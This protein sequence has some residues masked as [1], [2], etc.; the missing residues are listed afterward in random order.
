MKKLYFLLSLCVLYSCSKEIPA[1]T[2]S[3]GVVT[4]RPHIWAKSITDDG[5]L[6]NTHFV[7]EIATY[8]NKLVVGARKNGQRILRLL[9]INNGNTQWDWYDIIEERGY[10][11]LEQPVIFDNKLIWQADYWNYCIDFNNGQTVWKNAFQE[12]YDI[13]PTGLGDKFIGMYNYDR[14]SN[15]PVGGGS[16]AVFSKDNGK[17][18]FQIQPIYD[19]TSAQPF[20]LS[21]QRGRV[22][23]NKLFMQGTDTLLL[24]TFIDPP[25]YDYNYRQCLALY[26]LT[27]KQ[28]VY[29]RADML[30][31]SR[32][33]TGHAPCIYQ[34]KVYS[35]FVGTMVCNDLMTGK[36]LWQSDFDASDG[37]ATTGLIVVE[38]KIY[39]NSD[40]GY[41]YCWNS[42]TGQ[43]LWRI[44]TSGTSSRL[45]SLN[46][47]L[48]F[49]GS[50]DGK[51]HAIEAS[52]GNYLWKL[53]SPDKAKNTS[54]VFTGLCAVISG[55]NGERGKVIVL[56]GLNA[57]CYE[58]E[59]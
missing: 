21:H 13:L 42:E 44:R 53:D 15:R 57:Y 5:T 19:T 35:A 10:L 34:G 27:K 1:T 30:G 14:N 40:S 45:S 31:T 56:T 25:L 47:V 37:F 38:G 16:A 51:L 23:F 3:N 8:D 59:R 11:V 49:T 32:N 24:L 18:Y 9:D 4:G 29:D 50:G 33:N 12:N 48:Y 28:W 58:A 52:T 2:D 41:M 17:P 6:I 36:K 20:E 26:N 55:K 54:A 39:G 46:G 43:Q 22:R 7:Q